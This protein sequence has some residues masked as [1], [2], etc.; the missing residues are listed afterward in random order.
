MVY[1]ITGVQVGSRVVNSVNG[2]ATSPMTQ[3]LCT[4]MLIQ[5]Q[6]VTLILW[7]TSLMDKAVLDITSSSKSRCFL[8]SKTLSHICLY[9]TVYP[10]QLIGQARLCTH[11]KL[12]TSKRNEIQT[13][14]DS[15]SFSSFT[16]LY[17]KHK[18]LNMTIIHCP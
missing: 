18:F 7:L 10:S 16:N 4:F 12:L 1:F 11:I 5:L 9:D 8:R 15:F 3:I 13:N 6:G 2:S 17:I 14:V